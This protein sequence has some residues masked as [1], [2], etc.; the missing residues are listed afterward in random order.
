MAR[1]IPLTI[2]ASAALPGA[3]AW[4]ALGHATVAYVATNFVAPETKTYMQQLLGDTSDNYLASVA[5]WADTYRYTAEGKY[6]APYH[7]IDALDDPPHSCGVDLER[8][9][10]AEGCI[11]SAYANYTQHLLDASLALAQRQMAAKMV[12]HFTGDIGQP[13]HCENLDVGGND[14][15]V[16]FNGTKTNLHAAWDT[17]IPESIAGD[18]KNVLTVAKPW[19]A[20]LTKDIKSGEF[21]ADAA[22][23][24]VS[25]IDLEDPEATALAWAAESNAFVCTVV[26]PNGLDAVEKKE[27]GGAYTTSAKSTVSMQ[28]AK[29]GYRLAKWLDAIVAELA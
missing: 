18:G 23:P 1:L 21:S 10:G 24:W 15:V 29:Q 3:L 5:S 7:F 26:M 17:S 27:I 6:S 2:L 19:A 9:C 11:I 20:A 25:N 13:L 4:G 28:I 14:V 12:I 8:D 22:G 16:T